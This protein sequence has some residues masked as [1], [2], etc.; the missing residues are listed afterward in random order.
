MLDNC[1]PFGSCRLQIPDFNVLILSPNIIS[2][3]SELLHALAKPA[4]RLHKV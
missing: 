4:L 3:F 2:L 1:N